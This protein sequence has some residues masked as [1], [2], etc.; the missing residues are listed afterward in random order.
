[1]SGVGTEM[2]RSIGRHISEH[3][4]PLPQTGSGMSYGSRMLVEVARQGAE[5]GLEFDRLV[6]FELPGTVPSRIRT[7]TSYFLYEW[8]Q[9]RMR[10]GTEWLEGFKTD[11]VQYLDTFG[12]AGRPRNLPN[13]LSRDKRAVARNFWN[14]VLGMPTGLE[15]MLE[16]IDSGTDIVRVNG[17]SSRTTRASDALIQHR[18]GGQTLYLVSHMPHGG[19]GH[20]VTSPVMASLDRE[21]RT[22]KQD[23]GIHEISPFDYIPA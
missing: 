3:D 16:L 11:F 19:I 2:A 21:L 15:S 18:L 1:M 5:E 13:F 6:N 4:M 9:D 14:S 23:C 12:N 8:V 17:D 10:F 22:T 20:V 7:H